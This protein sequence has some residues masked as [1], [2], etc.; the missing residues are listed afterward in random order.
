ML[1]TTTI[2]LLLLEFLAPLAPDGSSVASVLN[3]FD[4]GLRCGLN[5]RNNS[6]LQ[7]NSVMYA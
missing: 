7:D 5:A 6:L 3:I 1:I 4:V 2:D